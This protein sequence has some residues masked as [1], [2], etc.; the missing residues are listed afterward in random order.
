MAR[1]PQ[2]LRPATAGNEVDGA[3]RSDSAA[4]I[5][6]TAPGTNTTLP[7]SSLRRPSLVFDSTRRRWW[8]FSVQSNE[9]V[10]G[11]WSDDRINWSTPQTVPGV[12]TKSPV[13]GTFQPATDSILLVYNT[14]DGNPCPPCSA[15][16]GCVGEI[17]ALRMTGSSTS[18]AGFGS[19]Y[20]FISPQSSTSM[21]YAGFGT[22]VLACENTV[23]A[24]TPYQCE[25]VATGLDPDRNTW[26]WKFSVNSTSITGY[27][28]AYV[29]GGGANGTISIASNGDSRTGVWALAVKGTDGVAYVNTKAN[30]NAAWGT[31][32]W[33]YTAEV[34]YN[35]LIRPLLGPVLRRRDPIPGMPPSANP[36]WTITWSEP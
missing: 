25:I 24:A 8:A 3:I 28:S 23:E 31:F 32:V 7:G 19:T 22:P 34:G 26:G 14:A 1:I 27:S 16:T 18:A 9:T 29:V 15:T 6:F 4:A 11:S 30:V 35:R 33:A 13:S 17:R 36:E 20:R 2:T 5:I 21:A 12:K 10:V